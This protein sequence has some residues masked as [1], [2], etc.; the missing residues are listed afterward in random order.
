MT[1]MAEFSQWEVQRW[2]RDYGNGPE[3][4]WM[5]T[6]IYGNEVPWH[7]TFDTEEAAERAK[8]ALNALRWTEDDYLDNASEFTVAVNRGV[9]SEFVIERTTPPPSST[10][11]WK[12][13]FCAF[14]GHSVATM[15]HKVTGDEYPKCSRCGKWGVD[16]A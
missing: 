2:E 1:N 9:L 4:M 13:V 14:K 5:V 11:R 15:R 12:G 16:D 8:N 6:N 7:P 3:P 10:K